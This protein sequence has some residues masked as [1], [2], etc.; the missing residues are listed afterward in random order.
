MLR[1]ETALGRI[2]ILSMLFA[3]NCAQTELRDFKG[4]RAEESGV[5]VERRP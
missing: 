3:K 1:S 5:M 4:R 2:P